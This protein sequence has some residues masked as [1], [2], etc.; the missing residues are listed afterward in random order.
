MNDV[1]AKR[2]QNVEEYV[3]ARLN[4]KSKD[5]EHSTGRNILDLGA[6]SPD[7][8]PSQIYRDKLAELIKAPDAH[9]YPG[10]GAIPEFSE[11]LRHWYQQRFN[12]TLADG[13]L[14]P[15]NGAKDGVVHLPLALFDLGDEVLIPDPGYPAFDVP[16]QLVG[17]KVVPYQLSPKFKLDLKEIEKKLTTHSKAIWVNFPSNPTGQVEDVDELVKLV[18]FAKMHKLLIL[19]DNAYSEITFDGYIAPSIL[20]VKGSEDLAVEIGSFSKMYS[21]AGYRIG[22]IAG[23]KEVIKALAKIKSQFDSGLSLPLQRLA[24]YALNNDDVS[25]HRKTIKEYQGR[26]NVIAAHLQKL[27]LSFVLPKG[28]LY[29]WAKL[30]DNVKSSENYCMEL[31]KKKQIM[32]T[33]GSAY[34]KNGEG[35]VRACICSDIKNIKEYFR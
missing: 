29:I 13:Q 27:G 2:V 9:L 28:A 33:P 32:M 7:I 24:A 21:F 12:V 14:L 22:W 34:G 31:L 3:F 30:P 15:L 6:G 10:Y 18:D 4:K 1:A 11:A 16:A 23:N 5:V 20:Q 8:P 17:A 19:Y 25:W 35:Y 26:R